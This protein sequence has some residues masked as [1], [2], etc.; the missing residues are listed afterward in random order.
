MARMTGGFTNRGGWGWGSAWDAMEAWEA[1]AIADCGMRNAESQ[2]DRRAADQ[3][4]KLS[5]Q[6][7]REGLAADHQMVQSRNRL[8]C[9]RVRQQQ[10]H[11]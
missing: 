4:S 1:G 10:A 8:P 6:I 5:R 2:H 3:A 11:H 7:G 9:L